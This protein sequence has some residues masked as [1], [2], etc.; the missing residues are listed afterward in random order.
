MAKKKN[1]LDV[2]ADSDRASLAHNPF[3]ALAG[4]TAPEQKTAPPPAD[5][6]AAPSPD[7]RQRSRGRLILRRETKH[8]GGKAVVVVAGLDNT[9]L[10][11]AARAELLQHLKQ[12]LGCGGTLQ[13]KDDKQEL[14]IQGDQPARVAELL[15]ARGF[16]V[17]GVT[18]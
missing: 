5:P 17:D 16:R 18:A 6:S 15:R 4:A 8:R 14:V 7:R 12:Q 1:K 3:A 11:D 13:D 9:D 10:D 2:S